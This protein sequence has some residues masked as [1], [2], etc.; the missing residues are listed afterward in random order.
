MVGILFVLLLSC[1]RLSKAQIQPSLVEGSIGIFHGQDSFNLN[2]LIVQ[3]STSTQFVPLH[4][5]TDSDLDALHAV[6]RGGLCVRVQGRQ[7]RSTFFADSITLCPDQKKLTSL[8]VIV[9][10]S[11]HD[12]QMTFQADGYSVRVPRGATLNFEG[13]AKSVDEVTPK[14]WARFSGELNSSGDLVASEVKFLQPKSWDSQGLSAKSNTTAGAKSEIEYDDRKAKQNIVNDD[15][16]LGFMPGKF[17]PSA[18]W[19]PL[20]R[21]ES[22]QE[23]VQR[24]GSR[25]VPEYQRVMGNEDPSKIHFRFFVIEEKW[26]HSAVPGNLGVIFIPK[27]VVERLSSDDQLAAILADGVAYQLQQQRA[28]LFPDRKLGVTARAGVVAATAFG[29]GPLLA[30]GLVNGI[31]NH[32]EEVHLAYDRSRLALHFMADAG[33]DPYQAPEAWRMLDSNKKPDSIRFAKYPG[34][35][36]YQIRFLMLQPS[37]G[38]TAEGQDAHSHASA[39]QGAALP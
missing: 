10:V 29:T 31:I 17:S 24:I 36:L 15:G 9:K 33:Y 35:S 22:V 37:L 27:T 39:L 12:G 6:L 11:S 23:R 19:R 13:L 30:A 21:E 5:H 16:A 8:A 18:D 32:E 7:N 14:T 4:G 38:A 1:L 2:D 3:L 26:P 34:I 20:A 28:A 25:V